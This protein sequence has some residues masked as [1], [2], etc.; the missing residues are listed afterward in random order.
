MGLLSRHNKPAVTDQWST[1]KPFHS[2]ATV[3]RVHQGHQVL[4]EM[5]VSQERTATMVRMVTKDVMV[6]F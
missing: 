5:M 2:V 1:L 3:N 6:R 4:Q